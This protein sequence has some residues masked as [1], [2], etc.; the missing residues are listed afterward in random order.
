MAH[1]HLEQMIAEW[2]EYQ[3]YFV[4]RNVLV[5]PR[6][7]GGYECEL[8]VVAFHPGDIE[9]N[10]KPHLVHLEP[11]LD[12]DSWAERERRYQKKFDAGKKYIKIQLFPKLLIPE[13]IEQIAVLVFASGA[14]HSTLGGG[15]VMMADQ[16]IEQIFSSLKG[17][18]L[19]SRA[20]P[21]QFT[22]LRSFQY[23]N[24]YKEVVMKIWYDR[25]GK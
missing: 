20:I 22:I 10:I 3:G 6:P 7:N 25:S 19:E 14:N 1:N 15:R 2:Y 11:S 9:K 12:A 5:G 23:V 24:Q 21:E 13:E 16:L 18:R 8:D 4:R 17:K